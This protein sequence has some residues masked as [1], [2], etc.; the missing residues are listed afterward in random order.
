MEYAEIG[1]GLLRQAGV[2]G[3]LDLRGARLDRGL[4]PDDDAVDGGLGIARLDVII[5]R[6][7]DLF[8]GEGELGTAGLVFHERFLPARAGIAEVD[9]RGLRHFTREGRGEE[10]F[11]SVDDAI[12]ARDKRLELRARERR[13]IARGHKDARGGI[14]EVIGL[15]RGPDDRDQAHGRESV[16]ELL[17][18]PGVEDRVPAH[19][20]KWV[21]HFV[22]KSGPKRG[23]G[24]ER[25]GRI[26]PR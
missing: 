19:R 25:C 1:Y 7:L 11:A 17:E 20:R 6:L 14:G 9:P 5:V 16:A 23:I 24:R 4:R 3:R 18:A 26:A 8:P 10:H 12:V 15:E 21:L 2:S 13:D 22:E